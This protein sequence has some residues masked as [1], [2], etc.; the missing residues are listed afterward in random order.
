VESTKGRKI[1]VGVPVGTELEAMSGRK[2][3]ES[4]LPKSRAQRGTSFRR[5]QPRLGGAVGIEPIAGVENT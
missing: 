2:R 4:P 3:S 1:A 5:I